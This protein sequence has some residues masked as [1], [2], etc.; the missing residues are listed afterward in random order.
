M[1]ARSCRTP[2][3]DWSHFPIWLGFRGGKGVATGIGVFAVLT[4]SPCSA[5]VFVAIFWL[6]VTSR[7]LR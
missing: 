2:R 6:R 1:V 4:R 5:Q 7:Q 3:N